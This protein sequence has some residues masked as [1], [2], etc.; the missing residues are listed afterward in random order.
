MNYCN[1][2]RLSLFSTSCVIARV[3]NFVREMPSCAARTLARWCSAI[4]AKKWN[5]LTACFFVVDL[6]G[7]SACIPSIL[8]PKY[9]TTFVV[10]QQESFQNC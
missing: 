6:L 8:V 9:H 3:K 1:L 2:N 4:E 7:L 5:G 10:A